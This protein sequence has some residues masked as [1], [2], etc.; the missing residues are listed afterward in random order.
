MAT[1]TPSSDQSAHD[2]SLS[3]NAPNASKKTPE[4]SKSGDS[5]AG[6]VEHVAEDAKAPGH[7][8]PAERP[9]EHGGPTGPEPTRYGDWERKGR[10]SDF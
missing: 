3:E 9:T 2:E 6:S 7:D 10:V 1:D 4:T 5:R 8:L